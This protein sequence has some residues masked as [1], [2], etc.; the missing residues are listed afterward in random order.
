MTTLRIIGDVHG[1]VLADDG[2]VPT[3]VLRT[4]LQAGVDLGVAGLEAPE[5]IGAGNGD[6]RRTWAGPGPDFEIARRGVLPDAGP[7]GAGDRGD[8]LGRAGLIEDQHQDV[9]AAR[10]LGQRYRESVCIISQVGASRLLDEA[11]ARRATR[12]DIRQREIRGRGDSRDRCGN[13]ISS[14]LRIGGDRGSTRDAVRAGDCG[15]GGRA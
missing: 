9:T 13:G 2:N 14:G 11:R 4:E 5:V 10:R 8:G 12:R 15:R 3:V 6:G 7:S 1:Q